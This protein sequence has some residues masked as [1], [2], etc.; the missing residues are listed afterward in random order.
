MTRY[1]NPKVYTPKTELQSEREVE[2]RWVEFYKNSGRIY[3]SREEALNENSS[4]MVVFW[5]GDT[6][7]EASRVPAWEYAPIDDGHV[8]TN[9]GINWYT[10][11]AT[12]EESLI[13]AYFATHSRNPQNYDYKAV[14]S[15]ITYDAKLGVYS[16]HI[17]YCDGRIG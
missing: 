8:W 17:H 4:C 7:M 5:D 15:A 3:A 13:D 11:Y 2:P 12:D 9:S 6:L 16:L 1:Y 10:D 14:R